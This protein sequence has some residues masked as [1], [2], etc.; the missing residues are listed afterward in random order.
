M[1]TRIEARITPEGLVIP[2]AAIREW[3]EQGIEVIKDEER[4][5]I[6]PQ[7]ASLTEREHVLQ[8]LEEDGL[9]VKPEWQPTSPP[10]SDAELSELAK[11]LSVGRPLS[12]IVI[13]E[14]EEGW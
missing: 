1:S 4:I 7:S 2:H 14:R 11:K 8:I 13:E 3:L 12:E 6:Q 10:V 5:V 9:L